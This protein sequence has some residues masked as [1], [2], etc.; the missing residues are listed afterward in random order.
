M[1]N[2]VCGGWWTRAAA[3]TAGFGCLL[4]GGMC[5]TFPGRDRN[6]EETIRAFA[7][8]KEPGSEISLF[9]GRDLSGWAAHGLGKWSVREGVLTVRRGIGYL[10]T[11]YDGWEDFILS[12][13]VRVSEQGN[14]GV[15]FRARHPGFGW[16]PWPLGYEAQVDNHDPQNYT[17]SLYNRV[18]VTN[19]AAADE[20]WFAMR[21]S[22]VDSRIQIQI[23]GETVVDATDATF[24]RGFI[25][26]QAHD[27]FSRVDFRGIRVR[28]PAEADAPPRP[29]K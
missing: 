10:A 15:F 14:S 23:N 2:R 24:D 27:P 22:A 5:L 13:D 9:N 29:G 4:L 19:T 6:F 18:R 7:E 1:V 21:V 25:A 8:K 28:I 17:G 12:L 3:V 11:R 26:L 20:E 16:R